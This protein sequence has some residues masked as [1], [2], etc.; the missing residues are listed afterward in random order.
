LRTVF[1]LL[2]LCLALPVFCQEPSVE[3]IM[4]KHFTARGG[5]TKLKSLDS[6]RL[7]GVQVLMPAPMELPMLIEL[8]RPNKQRVEL[9]VKGMTQITTFDGKEGWIKTPWAAEKNAVPL[10]PEEIEHLAESE[11]GTPYLDWQTKGWKTEC[12]GVAVVDGRNAHRVRFTLSNTESIIG[13]FDVRTYQEV[14]RERTYRNLGNELTLLSIF[15]DYQMVQGI[16]FP[17]Y[18]V[19]RAVSRGR[20]LKLLLDKIDV[21]PVLGDQRFT[22]P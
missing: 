11:F 14:Q 5:V 1:H 18:I 8:K 22:K 10:R 3:T 6:I 15:D 17:F 21:N 7:K 16:S 9:V 20:R 4:N 19:H 12:L 2:P 13:S